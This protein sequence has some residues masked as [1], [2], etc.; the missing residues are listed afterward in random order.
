MVAVG[1]PLAGPCL[2]VEGGQV[3]GQLSDFLGRRVIVGARCLDGGPTAAGQRELGG[4]QGVCFRSQGE[5]A[6]A[7]PYAG[8]FVGS[9]A[10]LHFGSLC[11][12]GEGVRQGYGRYGVTVRSV[13]GVFLDEGVPGCQPAVGLVELV[14]DLL[15]QA[16]LGDVLV[17]AVAGAFQPG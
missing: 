13:E 6:A 3:L 12:E 4:G 14:L 1:R 9:D 17:P 7:A 15:G 11:E 2:L 8:V 10:V 5:D 16:G